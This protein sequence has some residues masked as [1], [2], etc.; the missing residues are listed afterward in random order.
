MSGARTGAHSGPQGMTGAD[1]GRQGPTV[2]QWGYVQGR[3]WDDRV[4]RSF[5]QWHTGDAQGMTENTGSLEP[6]VI[7]G[8]GKLNLQIALPFFL[9]VLACLCV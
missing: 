5:V 1:R 6:V 2:A 7:G 3:T 4:Y 8:I 9:Q